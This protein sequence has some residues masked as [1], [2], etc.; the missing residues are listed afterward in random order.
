EFANALLHRQHASKQF[1]KRG[2]ARA[3]RTDEHGS[4]AALRLKLQA[5]VNNEIAIRVVDILQ[6]NDAMPA[7]NRLRKMKLNC[8]SA[9]DRRSDLFH[10]IDLLQFALGLRRLACLGPKAIGE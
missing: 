10:S 8:L 7:A 9:R 4:L 3:V 1:E 6:N 5:T 2:F